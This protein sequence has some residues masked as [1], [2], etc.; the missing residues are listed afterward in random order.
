MSVSLAILIQVVCVALIL[1]II[2][3]GI[4]N[5]IKDYNYD[6][7]KHL[8][9]KEK[10]RWKKTKKINNDFL[11]DKKCQP[12]ENSPSYVSIDDIDY[13]SSREHFFDLVIEFSEE[14]RKA[15]G[16][17]K[18]SMEM[19]IRHYSPYIYRTRDLGRY[20]VE[21]TKLYFNGKWNVILTAYPRDKRRMK[22]ADWTK[23]YDS[24]LPQEHKREAILKAC[25]G[26]ADR[27]YER[28]YE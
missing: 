1:L 24:V 23:R 16:I 9:K 7:E 27:E 10:K 11:Q 25:R 19:D 2:G 8:E 21:P 26:E 14:M 6:Y 20:L 28:D 18:H 22:K 3:S 15:L 4:Y 17:K 12:D 13:D 5:L